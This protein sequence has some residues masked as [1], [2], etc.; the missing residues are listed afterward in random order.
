MLARYATNRRLGAALHLQAFAALGASP[1]ARDY[2]DTLR[3]RNIGHHPALRQRANRLVGILHGCLKTD[4]VYD[5][6]TS[7]ATSP[8]RHPHR[9]LT[10]F[11]MGCL[12]PLRAA[13]P[14]DCRAPINR[15]LPPR[16]VKRVPSA[17]SCG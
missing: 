1:G 16:G 4:T 2:Y 5:A 8:N 14:V 11:K 3:G 17:I 13:D 12:S 10:N 9:R 7:L 6:N 15:P